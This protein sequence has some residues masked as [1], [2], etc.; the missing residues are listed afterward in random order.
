MNNQKR[1]NVLEQNRVNHSGSASGASNTQ[2]VPEPTS[3]ASGNPIHLDVGELRQ[4][5]EKM[6]IGLNS[7]RAQRGPLAKQLEEIDQG[8]NR[9][10]GALVMLKTL[11]DELDPSVNALPSM[12]GG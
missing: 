6:T 4:R 1:E 9:T 11:I 8:I 7:L 12:M 3:P 5:A 2:R 10:E